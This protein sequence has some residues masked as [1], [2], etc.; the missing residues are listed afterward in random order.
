M[1]RCCFTPVIGLLCL[2]AS[3]ATHADKALAAPSAVELLRELVQINST[4]AHG[5]TEAAKALAARFL[6]AGFPP[7]DV[8]FLA[9]ADHP[10]KGNL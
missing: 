6:A 2:A 1:Y 5:S 8:T 3:D 7:Q 9:P 4:H 10:S